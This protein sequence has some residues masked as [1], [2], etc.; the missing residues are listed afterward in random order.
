MRHIV[1]LIWVGIL[2]LL[3]AAMAGIRSIEGAEIWLDFANTILLISIAI[4]L[5][6]IVRKSS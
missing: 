2:L 4:S 5:L 3:G 1:L 6:H